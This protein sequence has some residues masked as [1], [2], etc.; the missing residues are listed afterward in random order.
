MKGTQV[1]GVYTADPKKD[2]TATKLEQLSYMEVIQK[3][4]RVMDHTATTLCM[5][6]K[7]PIVVFD[8]TQKGAVRSLLA[9]QSIGTLVS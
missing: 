5:E 7:L 6:N 8:L 3:D 2:T 9:G 1:D 4:L